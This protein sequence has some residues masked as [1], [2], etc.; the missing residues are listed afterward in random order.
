M[1]SWNMFTAELQK[2]VSGLVDKVCLLCGKW[3]ATVTAHLY[4]FHG[5][6]CMYNSRQYSVKHKIDLA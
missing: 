2:F 5:Y 6:I 4:R 1:I 3:T